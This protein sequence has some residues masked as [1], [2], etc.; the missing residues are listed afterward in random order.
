[1]P[2]RLVFLVRHAKAEPRSPDDDSRRITAK[3]RAR[4]S[5]LVVALGD[6]IGVDRVVTSPLLRARETAEI[7]ARAKG[8][9]VEEDVRLSAGRSSAKELLALVRRAG[10][11]TA[12]VG[13][14]PEIAEALALVAGGDLDVKP[15]AVAALEVH[16][17]DLALA[18]IEA[19]GKA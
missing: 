19:P 15:G 10:P 4:F 2:S 3:G 18:W 5:A 1:M 9:P 13:H 14:N 16:G 12:L 6:R 8:C 7:L 11:G 17:H